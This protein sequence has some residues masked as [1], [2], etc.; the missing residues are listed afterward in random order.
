MGAI[1]IFN[2]TVLWKGRGRAEEAACSLVSLVAKCG[3]LCQLKVVTLTQSLKAVWQQ[4]VA[5]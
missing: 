3:S 5:G 2:A 1:K 4:N